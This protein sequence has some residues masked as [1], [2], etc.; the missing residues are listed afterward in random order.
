MGYNERRYLWWD[1]RGGD[2]LGGEGG[3]VSISRQGCHADNV[4]M[5]KWVTR[6]IVLTDLATAPR[7][8]IQ[9][10]DTGHRKCKDL[11]FT[12]THLYWKSMVLCFMTL[13]SADETIKWSQNNKYTGQYSVPIMTSST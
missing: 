13:K 8:I 9:A 6:D 3:E 2:T 11:L 1:I 5:R 12:K 4:G 10:T 7:D